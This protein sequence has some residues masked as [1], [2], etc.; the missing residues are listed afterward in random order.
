MP[1]ESLARRNTPIPYPEL[2]LIKNFRLFESLEIEWFGSVNLIVG[3]NNFRHHLTGKWKLME[4]EPKTFRERCQNA[5]KGVNSVFTP[6]TFLKI[7]V[8]SLAIISSIWIAIKFSGLAPFADRF[9]I[10]HKNLIYQAF[11]LFVLVK[12]LLHLPEMLAVAFCKALFKL[13]G[14]LYS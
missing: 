2:T 14:S 12:T 3:R 8:Q 6:L 7:A 5:F 13:K 1:G 4:P 11:F 10:D 9:Y